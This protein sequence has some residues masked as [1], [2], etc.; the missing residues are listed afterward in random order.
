MFH[1]RGHIKQIIHRTTEAVIK[2]LSADGD[3][4]TGSKATY[5][6]IDETHVLGSKSKASE[7][8]LEL[9]GGLAS[10]PEGFLLQITTQSKKPPSGQFKKE[11]EA[12]RAVRD[13]TRKA[14]VLAVLYELPPATAKDDGWKDPA[15]WGL[16]NPNLG[17]S[18]SLDYLRDQFERAEAD[19]RDAMALFASQHLNVQI[20]QGLI[21][22]RWA[23]TGFWQSSICK[24]LTLD[25]LIDRCE[26]IVAGIDGGGLDDLLGLTFIGREKKSKRWMSWSKAWAHEIVLTRRRSIAGELQDFRDAGQLTI[27]TR[28]TQDVDEVVDLICKVRDAGLLPDRDA[29]GLDP[30]G[31]AAILDALIEAEIAEDQ[32]R[33]V[34]QGYK[35]NGAI[36][37]AERKLFDGTLV[38][39][40]QPMMT[41]CVSNA[42]TE[43]RGNATVV[44]KAESGTA[45]IDPLMALFNAVVLMNQ[46]PEATGTALD[47]FLAN[48][49]MVA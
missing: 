35:L 11:L 38:H 22:G 8:F 43:H 14:P 4:V 40:D 24:D 1:V 42:K 10:R 5:V 44:T 23:G 37:G 33:G 9:R 15:L 26:V 20:G 13:G 3:V 25:S 30:E 32:L 21:D 49:V 18:V 34:S 31:V 39:A 29:I 6:L 45:K 2:V 48:P 16:V 28:P 17:R 41:W 46:N 7:I 12:A 47:D 19:G 27:C 36:K